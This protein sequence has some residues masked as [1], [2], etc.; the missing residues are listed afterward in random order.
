[1]SNIF[2]CTK[3]TINQAASALL[4]GNLVAFPTETVYGLG[5]DAMNEKAIL[6]IYEVKKR[7]KNHPIIVHISSEELISK[8]ARKIPNYA[9]LL[10]RR[11]WPGP[12][13]LILARTKLAKDFVTGGQD[14]VGLRIPNH[15]DAIKLLAGFES[16]GGLGVAAPSA[17]IFGKLSPTTAD[18][19]D[20]ELGEQFNN[21]DII[22][23]GGMCGVGLE[24]TIIDCRFKQ[25]N[26]LRSGAV[27]NEMIEEATGLKLSN[28][29]MSAKIRAPG[30][31]RSH[32]SPNADIYL[33]GIPSPGDGF[34]ALRSVKTPKGAIRL[35][36]P[37][38]DLQYARI[39]YHALRQADKR[40]IRRVFVVLPQLGGISTAIIDR[41]GRATYRG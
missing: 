35:A 15:K 41:L 10:A 4:N 1:M 30:S 6:R 7:P 34:I 31:L 13:T 36:A 12:M 3:L 19:V 37:E 16:L 17:N 38:D 8:W 23:D 21:T 25:P 40:S 9:F 27:T 32:Y 11:F 22:L 39:L 24:S 2:P 29:H 5:A 26:V 28:D 14:C 33:D 18:A 20:E